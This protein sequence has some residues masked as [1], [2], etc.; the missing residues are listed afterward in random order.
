MFC[1]SW[2]FKSPQNSGFEFSLLKY[3]EKLE[4]IQRMATK[5]K[6][7]VNKEGLWEWGNL[8]YEENKTAS[9]VKGQGKIDNKFRSISHSKERIKCHALKSLVVGPIVRKENTQKHV[10]YPVLF[11][12][13]KVPF[14]RINLR[15]ITVIIHNANF[16][17]MPKSLPFFLFFWK[18]QK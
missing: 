12:C 2:H 11:Y 14:L 9:M 5:L 15:I 8:S 10:N 3:I 1:P 6:S 13:E 7:L 18:W 4:E 16:L 17:D